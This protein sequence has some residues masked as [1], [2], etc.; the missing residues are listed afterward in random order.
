MNIIQYWSQLTLE[1]R[2]TYFHP[3]D[4]KQHDLLRQYKFADDLIPVPYGGDIRNAKIIFTM[5]NPGLQPLEKAD[6]EYRIESKPEMQ[7]ALQLNLYQQTES[8]DF[9]FMYL[10]PALDFHPGYGYWYSR[11]NKTMVQYAARHS[12]SQYDA[13]TRFAGAVAILEL[14]PYHS[15]IYPNKPIHTTL[16]S[17]QQAKSAFEDL[18]SHCLMIVPRAHEAWGLLKPAP[19]VVNIV[20]NTVTIIAAV[21]LVTELDNSLLITSARRRTC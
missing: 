6:S 14:V 12:C 8:L 15:E 21:G 7:E 1:G 16:P 20:G 11:L 19:G 18:S 13:Q 17:S 5:K 4:S 3:A 9:P 10:N 2:Q